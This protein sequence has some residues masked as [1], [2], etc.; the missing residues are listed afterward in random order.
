MRRRGKGSFLLEAHIVKPRVVQVGVALDGLLV[1]EALLARD[2]LLDALAVAVLLL[3]LHVPLVHVRRLRLWQGLQRVLINS[4][5]ALAL[6][7]TLLELGE[8]D[9]QRL[10][11]VAL[12][13]LLH[14]ALVHLSLIHI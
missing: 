14:R 11:V 12:V 9:E 13:E 6:L 4:T 1:L 8:P 2:H 3:K 5:R 7:G 10:G